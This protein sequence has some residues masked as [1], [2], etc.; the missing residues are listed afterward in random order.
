MNGIIVFLVG[1]IGS[2]FGFQYKQPLVATSTP[3]VAG[4]TVSE[5][6]SMPPLPDSVIWRQETTEPHYVSIQN[7]S[8][9]STFRSITV[10]AIKW[11]ASTS[12]S[13]V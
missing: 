2:L 7:D 12:P 11:I 3:A 1:L 13:M 4:P 9:T 6:V 10:H 8:A 5:S